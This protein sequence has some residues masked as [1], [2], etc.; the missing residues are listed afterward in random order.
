MTKGRGKQAINNAALLYDTLKAWLTTGPVC[1]ANF[2]LKEVELWT[3][4]TILAHWCSLTTEE[5]VTDIYA[6]SEKVVLKRRPSARDVCVHKMGR[7]LRDVLKHM[8]ERNSACLHLAND[9]RLMPLAWFENLD[10][11]LCRAYRV[12]ND[13]RIEL[14]IRGWLLQ[15]YFRT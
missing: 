7:Q 4:D 2:E 15:G 14:S 5:I 10:D 8:R 9:E 3:K 11:V 13:Q 6:C 12:I 1:R